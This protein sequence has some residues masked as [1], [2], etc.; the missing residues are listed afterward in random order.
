[1]E[2][3]RTVEGFMGGKTRASVLKKA[4]MS[5]HR[6]RS[7]IAIWLALTGMAL[8]ASWPL[9]ANA[10]TSVPALPSEICSATGPK[11]A[12]E[13]LP[14]DA[15]GKSVQPSHCTLCPFNAERGPVISGTAPV[16]VS[17]APDCGRVREF[18]AGRQPQAALDP[19]APPRAPPFYS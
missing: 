17:P 2:N 14:G 6:S 13:S 19:P 1:V 4:A 7:R 16:L 11:P 8:N 10:K 3:T 9:L 15:P 5:A 18:F 12:G